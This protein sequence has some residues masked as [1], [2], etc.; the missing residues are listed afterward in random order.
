MVYLVEKPYTMCASSF[1]YKFMIC[2]FTIF[3]YGIFKFVEIT[4]PFDK[5]YNIVLQIQL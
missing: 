4:Y 2:Y 1:S 5:Y 3:R